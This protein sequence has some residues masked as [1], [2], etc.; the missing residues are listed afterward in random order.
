MIIV[1]VKD[2]LAKSLGQLTSI[3]KNTGVSCSTVQGTR[4]ISF[5][6]TAEGIQKIVINITYNILIPYLHHDIFMTTAFTFIYNCTSKIYQSNI[7]LLYL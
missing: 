6:Q 4:F 7:Q 5:I 1:E 3:L 2:Q